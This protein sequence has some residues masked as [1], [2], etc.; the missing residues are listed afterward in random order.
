VINRFP[1]DIY[2]GDYIKDIA[3]QLFIK[4]GDNVREEDRRIFKDTAQQ[5]NIF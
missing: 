4:H 2:Q 3:M 1:E 5:K